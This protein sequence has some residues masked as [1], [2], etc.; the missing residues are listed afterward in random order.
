MR[1][2][3]KYKIPCHRLNRVFGHYALTEEHKAR[4]RALAS[5]FPRLWSDPATPARERKWI[6]RLLIEDVTIVKADQIHLHVR[7]RGGATTSIVVPIPLK[8]Y[9]VHQTNPDTLAALDCLLDTH[10]DAQAAEAL[11]RDGHRSGTAQAFTP[12]IVLHL[13]RCNGLPSHLERLRAR[14]LLTIAEVAECFCVSTST[15]K[16]WHR[17]GLLISHQANDKNIRLFE[18]P[19]TGD[20]SLVKRM[21]RRLDKRVLTQPSTGSAV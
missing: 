17:A 5:D 21:G 16:A 19:T 2:R 1:W 11:N 7:F 10:T 9:Q 15:I 3:Q 20:P 6:T 14:G 8:S 18:Q 13:R 12:S 4:V